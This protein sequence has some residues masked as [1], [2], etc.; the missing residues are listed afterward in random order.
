MVV[1]GENY[2][3]KFLD[4]RNKENLCGILPALLSNADW[5]SSYFGNFDKEP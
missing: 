1:V 4:H 2:V 5:M 3:F